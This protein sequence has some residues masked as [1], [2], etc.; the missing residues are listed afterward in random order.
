MPSCQLIRSSRYESF[1][2]STYAASGEVLIKLYHVANET[3]S[4]TDFPA[5]IAIS[6]TFEPFPAAITRHGQGNNSLGIS[7]AGGN[8][9]ILLISV[10][11]TDCASTSSAEHIGRILLNELDNAAL[12]LG[13]LRRF[14]YMSYAHP[15]QDPLGAY[16]R[17]NLEFLRDVSLQYDPSGVFQAR[18]PGGFKLFK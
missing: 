8:G 5:E 4:S 7:P 10:S 15:S 9:V 13:G 6:L 3:L 2:T 17:K 1:Y 11:W 12:A 16:G 18:V 14:K